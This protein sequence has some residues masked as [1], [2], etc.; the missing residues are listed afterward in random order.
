[1]IIRGL[2]VA[3]QIPLLAVC[4]AVLQT[5]QPRTVPQHDH[6][7]QDDD[8]GEKGDRRVQHDED[9]LKCRS[10]CASAATPRTPPDCAD[11]GGGGRVRNHVLRSL[12]GMLAAASACRRRPR[13]HGSRTLCWLVAGGTC[14]RPLVRSGRVGAACG[15]LPSKWRRA[16]DCPC[17]D[18]ASTGD[19][20]N[21]T[22]RRRSGRSGRSRGRCRWRW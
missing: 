6:N 10:R 18:P 4:D 20:L 2:I 22:Q 21:S 15:A 13:I 16:N 11:A 19:A 17:V 3:L 9:H 5:A 14:A 7:D 1:M 12:L 8:H